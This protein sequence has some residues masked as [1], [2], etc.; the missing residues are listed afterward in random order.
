MSTKATLFFHWEDFHLYRELYDDDYVYL[1]LK[2]KNLVTI[3]ESGVTLRI[4]VEIMETIKHVSTPSLNLAYKSDEEIKAIVE[5]VVNDRVEN[6]KKDPENVFTLMIGS[7]T[8]G[9]PS[10]PIENQISAGMSNYIRFRDLQT[11]QAEKIKEYKQ[12]NKSK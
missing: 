12:I 5:E 7:A 11:R 1:N 2:D 6:Y 9:V 10:D 8:F 4:P 3:D